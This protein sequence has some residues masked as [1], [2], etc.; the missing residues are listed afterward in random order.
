M[1][2]NTV[3]VTAYALAPQ[4]TAYYENNR[5]M[6]VILEVD[7]ETDIIVD[8]AGTFMTELTTSFLKRI[9]VGANICT[10][11]ATL[12]TDIR[13]Q[14]LAPSSQSVITALKT[15]QQRYFDYKKK[16]GGSAKTRIQD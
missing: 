16:G 8:A 13:E 15:A 3:L 9:I 10:D 6:G 7:K 1:R 12:T 4:N 11:M 14:Y 2:V 5:Y